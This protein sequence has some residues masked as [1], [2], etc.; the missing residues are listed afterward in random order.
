MFYFLRKQSS[1]HVFDLFREFFQTWIR[2]KSLA[3]EDFE[4]I[5]TLRVCI[6]SLLGYLTARYEVRIE[7]SDSESVPRMYSPLTEFIFS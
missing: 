4:V 6:D 2:E 5:Y 3:K 1:S 7:K